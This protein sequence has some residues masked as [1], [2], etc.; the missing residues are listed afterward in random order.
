[1]AYL[2]C[3]VI[4]GFAF[5][6]DLAYGIAADM[7]EV[8]TDF[9]WPAVL[10][11]GGGLA[12][13]LGWFLGELLATFFAPLQ[14][15][16]EILFVPSDDVQDRWQAVTDVAETRFP[17]SAAG[18]IFSGIETGM[19]ASASGVI[20]G[21]NGVQVVGQPLALGSMVGTAIATVQPWRG[22]IFAGV[23]LLFIPRFIAVVFS[24]VGVTHTT[25]KGDG[26]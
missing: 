12:S 22:F 26:E 4:G 24:A 16:V 14:A 13:A 3:I 15:M 9:T 5:I 7:I 17:F 1:M 2:A 10:D 23:V 20:A 8:W 19:T 25:P 21:L 11:L 18:S 6:G